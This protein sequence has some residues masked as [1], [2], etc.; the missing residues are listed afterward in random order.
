MV[1]SRDAEASA[2]LRSFL[3]R[4]NAEADAHDALATLLATAERMVRETT[5]QERGEPWRR[6][7][8]A[9]YAELAETGRG[10]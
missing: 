10:R 6:L 7:L 2:L 4:R 1:E 9:L 5:G 3:D 8:R